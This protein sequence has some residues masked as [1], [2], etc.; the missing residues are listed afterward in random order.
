M[1]IS[2][3]LLFRIIYITLIV[4]HIIIYLILFYKLHKIKCGKALNLTSLKD[5]V[6]ELAKTLIN[7]NNSIISGIIEF[8][9]NQAKSSENEDNN[10]KTE[11]G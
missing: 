10:D 5:K 11:G 7:P 2:K 6:I 9:H 3:E 1:Y 4:I 8:I